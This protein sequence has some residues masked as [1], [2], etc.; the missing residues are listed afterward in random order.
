MNFT[1]V[2]KKC[3]LKKGLRAS[4]L[5]RGTGYSQQYISDLLSGNRRWNE[6]TISKIC[7]LLNIKVRFIDAN[8]DSFLDENDEK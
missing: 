5:A 4:D 7:H 6:T 1:K 2:V 8:D 3:M